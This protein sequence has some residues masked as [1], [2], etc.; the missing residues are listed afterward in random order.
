[1]PLI[2]A[3]L[4]LPGCSTPASSSSPAPAS[5]ALPAPTPSAAPTTPA[6]GRSPTPA[7][8]AAAGGYDTLV[9]EPGQGMGA[10]YQAIAGAQHSLDLVMY[11]LEDSIAVDDLIQAEKRGVSVRVILDQAYA[12]SENQAAYA[13][14][15]AGGVDV[16]WS[17]TQVDITHQKTLTVDSSKALIMTGN[18]TAQYYAST[19]DF[20]VTDTDPRDVAAIDAVF[21]ADFAST[22]IQPSSGDDLVWSP[23]SEPALA[24]LIQGARKQLLVENE[25]M[26]DQDI[27]TALEA[28]AERGVDVEVCMTDSSSW[29]SE[30][31]ALTR[32]GVRVYTVAFW[33]RREG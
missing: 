12:K 1:M 29:S 3:L 18:L 8:T 27:V 19:R 10:F 33:M 22:A 28:A 16:H 13:A 11:E 30:F 17:S 5:T 9:V 32:A 21:D 6:A 23:G 24:A 2:A 4:L 26:S 20:M 7:A 15:L 31:S 14:L 25:E